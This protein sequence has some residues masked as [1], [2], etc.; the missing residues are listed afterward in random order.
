MVGGR[1]SSEE[2]GEQSPTQLIVVVLH[3]HIHYLHLLHAKEK[4]E[5]GR[6]QHTKCGRWLAASQ[7]QWLIE[8][9]EEKEGQKGRHRLFWVFFILAL[10]SL[11]VGRL[12][13]LL[14]YTSTTSSLLRRVMFEDVKGKLFVFFDGSLQRFPSQP[15]AF[16]LTSYTRTTT[17][18]VLLYQRRLQRSYK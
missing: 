14:L 5:T 2:G 1:A 12:K 9:Q 17:Y 13:K 11:G 6:R 18:L 16:I 8:E 4:R 15:S 10:F 3:H 7:R